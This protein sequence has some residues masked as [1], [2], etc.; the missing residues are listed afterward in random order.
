MNKKYLILSIFLVVLNIGTAIHAMEKDNA[1]NAKVRKLVA[2]VCVGRQDQESFNSGEEIEK[3]AHQRFS[4]RWGQFEKF[5]TSLIPADSEPTAEEMERVFKQS[6]KEPFGGAD[7]VEF[8]ELSQK[9]L[10]IFSNQETL[11]EIMAQ[12]HQEKLF[13]ENQTREVAFQEVLS[14]QNQKIQ[15]DLEDLK[16]RLSNEEKLRKLAQSLENKE[17][18]E[19]SEKFIRSMDLKKKELEGRQK[20]YDEGQEKSRK[21]FENNLRNQE[22]RRDAER[23]R[24]EMIS[25]TV[26]ELLYS[27]NSQELDEI[28]QRLLDLEVSLDVI[29]NHVSSYD[30]RQK[31]QKEKENFEAILRNLEQYQAQLKEQFFSS[32]Q[33]LMANT[34]LAQ[35]L[36]TITPQFFLQASLP[37]MQEKVANLERL[38]LDTSTLD[39]VKR[40]C[41]YVLLARQVGI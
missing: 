36:S 19:R 38:G 24:Q 35:E 28:I 16:I 13:R 41:L 32:L 3:I 25:K 18:E 23:Q 34:L 10:M 11:S 8:Y 20:Q 5:C 27:K 26:N 14:S 31:Q 37:E 21:A 6:L 40:T 17:M 4:G 1:N 39:T 30:E 29:G 2:Q 22:G 7:L 33:N 12:N 15:Q 9:V